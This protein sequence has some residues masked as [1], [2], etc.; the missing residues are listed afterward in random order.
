ME[1][2]RQIICVAAAIQAAKYFVKSL[3]GDECSESDSSDEEIELLNIMGG[4][5]FVNPLHFRNRIPRMDN[6]FEIVVPKYSNEQFQSQFRLQRAAF[7][8]LHTRIIPIL[9]TRYEYARPREQIEKKL[10]AVI[11]LLATPDSYRLVT[12]VYV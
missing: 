12:F 5:G 7:G 11:W 10:L 4:G 8:Y 9:A 2:K 3:I 6:Y 1:R